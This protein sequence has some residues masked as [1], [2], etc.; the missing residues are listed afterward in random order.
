MTDI[1][2][3]IETVLVDG[4]S[5]AV[6]R[7][8]INN[9]MVNLTQMAKP[10]GKGKKPANW[11]RIDETKEYLECLSQVLDNQRCADMRNIDSQ[12]VSELIVVR[13]GNPLREQGTWC[14]DYRIAMRFAQ[15]LSPKFSIMVDDL[16]MRIANGERIVSESGFFNLG[17]KQWVGCE[18][19][20]AMFGKSMHSFYGLQGNYP[21][22]FTFWEGKWYMSRDLF[23][24]KE[25][26]NRFEVRRTT[27]RTKNDRQM[28]IPFVELNAQE[29]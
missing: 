3:Q 28:Q 24:M 19:Y 18:A 17:G 25:A 16:L 11:L 22:E 12:E 14:T 15:W 23:N 29:D 8:G 26:Q 20:C 6:E 21:R 27:M 2:N 10:F 4:I 13:Q 9:C 7:Q 1:K 5:V